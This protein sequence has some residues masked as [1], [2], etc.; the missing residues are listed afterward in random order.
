MIA[1]EER[2]RAFGRDLRSEHARV[3]ALLVNQSN[4]RRDP[5][6]TSH[7]HQS[8]IPVTYRAV[9][10]NVAAQD[11]SEHIVGVA[12]AERQRTFLEE[13]AIWRSISSSTRSTGRFRPPSLVRR[14]VKA[15][16]KRRRLSLV[17]YSV[18]CS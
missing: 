3:T 16:S 2:E 8:A 4:I 11:A 9:H 12:F 17:S 1:A 15:S 10:V 6:R 7:P 14:I 13:T 5:C 18:S